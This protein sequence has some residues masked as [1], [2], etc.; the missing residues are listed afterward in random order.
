MKYT[1][2]LDSPFYLTCNDYYFAII[3]YNKNEQSFK[4]KAF[5]INYFGLIKLPLSADSQEFGNTKYFVV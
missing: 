5:Y 2:S 4:L 1:H 3:K